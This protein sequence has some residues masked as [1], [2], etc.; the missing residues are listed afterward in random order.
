MEI[1]FVLYWMRYLIYRNLNYDNETG[2]LVLQKNKSY[3]KQYLHFH[4]FVFRSIVLISTRLWMGSYGRKVKCALF[5]RSISQIC[6]ESNRW[7]SNSY[8]YPFDLGQF[9]HKLDASKCSPRADCY[10][11]ATRC[12]I[13]RLT[14]I[15]SKRDT[16]FVCNNYCAI[17]I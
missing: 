2:F 17:T 5:T 6:I 13:L 4:C 3:C 11:A 12:K 8:R 14:A 1:N 7:L 10:R 9:E 16:C 15:N